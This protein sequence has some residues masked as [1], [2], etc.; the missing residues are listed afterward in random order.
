MYQFREYI[1]PISCHNFKVP[2]ATATTAA[3]KASSAA[4]D[5]AAGDSAAAGSADSGAAQPETY[6]W[7]RSGLLR[8]INF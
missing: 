6:P 3:R 8:G 1:S 2:A 7:L 5:S 4:A